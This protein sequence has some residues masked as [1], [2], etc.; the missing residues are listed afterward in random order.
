VTGGPLH[1]LSH[2]DI[3]ESFD[4]PIPH[5]HKIPLQSPSH[6]LLCVTLDSL[7]STL[8]S[9]GRSTM[10]ASCFFSSYPFS[11]STP[12]RSCFSSI[13]SC[14]LNAC[15][16]QRPTALERGESR[17]SGCKHTSTVLSEDSWVAGCVGL[18]SGSRTG[19]RVGNKMLIG[20][21]SE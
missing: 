2:G 21:S 4:T 11:L 18:Y 12:S 6:L 5:S 7:D 20:H 9:E 19:S 3:K 8:R 16:C 1:S 17:F 10:R 14:S 13:G 15:S